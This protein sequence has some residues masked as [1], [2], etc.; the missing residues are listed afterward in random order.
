M[1]C[2]KCHGPGVP[3]DDWVAPLLG[4]WDEYKPLV[5][6]NKVSPTDEAILLAS[7]HAHATALGTITLLICALMYA[8]RLPGI[9]KA[10]LTL[11]ASAGLLFDL[12][13]WWLARDNPAMI[14]LIIIGG[15]AHG[16]AMGLMMLLVI[17]DLW[18]PGG[19][20]GPIEDFS[21]PPAPGR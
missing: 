20:K 6:E 21:P 10:L 11:L 7:T 13:A 1:S 8:T 14:N 18:F 3:K 15:T 16:A 19:R 17:L 4:S 12:A 2:G 5:Y 9:F